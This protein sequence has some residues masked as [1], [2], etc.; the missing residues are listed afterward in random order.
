MKFTLPY[1]G[2]VWINFNEL[3]N[4]P[5][6]ILRNL[7]DVQTIERIGHLEYKVI[8]KPIR[9]HDALT[10]QPKGFVVLEPTANSVVWKKSDLH[11][12]SDCNGVI[13]GV[14]TATPDLTTYISGNIEIEHP[15]LNNMTWA[16]MKGIVK[17]H[18]DNYIQQF[19]KNFKDPR[20]ENDVPEA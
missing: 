15:W 17:K 11:D 12:A 1:S 20:Y 13:T 7:P 2:N 18:G 16:F 19:I 10:V 14:A 9:F 5:L 4:D 8:M 6:L 3:K